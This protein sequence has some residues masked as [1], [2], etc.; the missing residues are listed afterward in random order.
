M[1]L[2]NLGFAFQEWK[3]QNKVNEVESGN[4]SVRSPTLASCQQHRLW[5][6]LRFSLSL[7]GSLL[8]RH[9]VFPMLSFT[10]GVG[11]TVPVSQ[12]VLRQLHWG[13]LQEIH[14]LRPHPEPTAS[15]ILGMA[16]FL[17]ALWVITRQI[18]V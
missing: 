15:E 6:Q 8:V 3:F 9:L 7:V 16:Y 10:C 17:Q 13:T 2:Q 14:I 12:I 1:L 11:T 4:A 18:Q 5:G